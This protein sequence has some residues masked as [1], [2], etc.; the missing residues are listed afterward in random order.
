MTATDEAGFA[1]LAERIAERAGLDIGAYKD[2]CLRRRIA[3]RMRACNVL[4]YSDY[5]ALLEERPEEFDRLLDALTI[6]VTK[7]F[8]N[9]ETWEWLGAQLLPG[10][11]QARA[12]QLRVWSAGCASGEEPY[13]I[14]M[15]VAEVLARI[16]HPD[17]LPR[18]RIDATDIDR[19]SMDRAQAARFPRRAFSEA[20]PGMPERYCRVVGEGD[21]E[22]E[23]RAEIRRM[24]EIRTFDL[25][26]DRPP[27]GRYDLVCC[28]NVV[29]Y[30]DRETQER[31]MNLFADALAAE[32]VLVLG[33]VETILGAAR[34]RYALLEPRERIYRKIA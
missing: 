15:L 29:I 12:G 6:N 10:M 34:H 2:R 33:K 18:V 28:R 25:T 14:A 23:I 3:V 1:A 19:H 26:H 27:L 7:F 24:V 11:L 21:E 5:V 31:L 9:R 17:W 20:D 4:R 32:G 13:T 16:G 30:F 22:L 8:R